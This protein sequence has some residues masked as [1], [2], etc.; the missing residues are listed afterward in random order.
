MSDQ[1]YVAAWNDARVYDVAVPAKPR[2]S[3]PCG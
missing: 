1:G 2:F 3:A